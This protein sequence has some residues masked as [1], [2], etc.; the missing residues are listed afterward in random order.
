MIVPPSLSVYC[1][2]ISPFLSLCLLYIYLSLSLSVYCISIH[3]YLSL[4]LSLSLCPSEEEVPVG[5]FYATFL[6]QDY[7][8]KFRKRKEKD[9]VAVGEPDPNNPSALQ[10]PSCVDPVCSLVGFHVLL[11]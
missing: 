1:M 6:I 9:G 7:F 5:K 3:L 10:V 4:S 8:R 11:V 2:S